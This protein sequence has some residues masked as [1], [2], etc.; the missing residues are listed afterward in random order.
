MKTWEGLITMSRK[1]APRA[2]LLKAALAGRVSNAE[3][4]RSLDLSIRQVQRLKGR[5][6]EAGVRGLVHRGRGRASPRR[7]PPDVRDRVAALLRDTYWDF[8]DCHATEKLREVEGLLVSRASVRRLR[9]ALGVPAKHPRRPHQYRRR[10]PPAARMGALVQLD[11]SLEPWFGAR[12]PRLTLHGAIDDATSTV[13]A[14]HFRP[15]EDLHGYTTLLAQLGREYGLPVAFYGDHLNVFI[16][17]DE[18][19]SLAEQLQGAQDPTHFGRILATLGIG[20]IAAGSPQAK[21]RVER[22]WGTLQDRLVAELRLRGIASL[23]AANAFLPDFRATFNRHFAHAPTDAT[24]AWRPAP[25]DF[26]NLLSCGYERVV[27][28]DNTVRL[29]DRLVQLAPGRGG[30]SYAGCRVEVRECLDGRLLV[31]ALGGASLGLQPAPGPDFVL[32]PRHKTRGQPRGASRSAS[33]EGGRPL[34]IPPNRPSA[35]TP[36]PAARRP[37]GASHPWRRPMTRSFSST[38]PPRG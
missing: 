2:G 1:E 28:R 26:A 9:R 37:P 36:R 11:G 25:P 4:A 15:G 8:N 10:R 6:H 35:P 17:T 22:L 21:G 5:F 14:L 34:P 18:H 19:W 3:L 31:R 20:F 33:D 29:G 30:R 23:E 32:I 16:R 24:P 38:A 12:G 7:L 27:A 13:L